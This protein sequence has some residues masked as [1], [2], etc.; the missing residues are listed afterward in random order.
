VKFVHD[1]ESGSGDA[2]AILR[3]N[4]TQIDRGVCRPSCPI[5]LT[6]VYGC[7]RIRTDKSKLGEEFKLSNVG[8]SA[9]IQAATKGD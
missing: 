9:S 5:L 6:S 4:A 8:A 7:H 1:R 2:S 3:Y